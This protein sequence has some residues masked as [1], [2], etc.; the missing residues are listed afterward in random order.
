[1]IDPLAELA[2]ILARGYVRLLAAEAEKARNS[3]VP[4]P[5]NLPIPLEVLAPEW[6]AVGREGTR[7]TTR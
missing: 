2:A 4:R 7:V 6:P 1:M 5:E 3:A